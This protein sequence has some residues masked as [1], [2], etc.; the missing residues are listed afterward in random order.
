MMYFD[1]HLHLGEDDLF[2]EAHETIK[3]AYQ[4]EVTH[5]LNIATDLITLERGISLSADYPHLYLSA[6]I[7]P[8]SAEKA[9]EDAL[10]P[11][12]EAAKEG[13]LVAIG[14][15]GLDHHYYRESHHQQCRLLNKHLELAHSLHLPL[16]FHCREAF[17]ALFEE[18]D[19]SLPD[20][21]CLVH[22]F[23]GSFE[24][25]SAALDRGWLLSVS[26]VIT[27][28]KSEELREVVKRLPLD[29]LTIET[30]A[31][32]LTPHPW[33]GKV[34]A[35]QYVKETARCLA[36]LHSTTPEEVARVTHAT[37]CSFLGID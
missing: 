5:L 19:S 6:A 35:P 36:E 21:P 34:N 29:R 16:I 23:T 27:Y 22:C 10:L 24:E 8:H 18:M 15:T 13:L 14:E 9:P 30:D 33:R 1:S 25:A 28:P 31:P 26:G 3:K 2:P 12:A 37:T 11:I 4:T 20:W 17:Q 7:P 32:Y